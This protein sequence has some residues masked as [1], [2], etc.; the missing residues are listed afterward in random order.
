MNT[1]TWIHKNYDNRSLNNLSKNITEYNT[2]MLLNRGFKVDFSNIIPK[3]GKY[4]V[5]GTLFVDTPLDYYTVEDIGVVNFL[6]DHNVYFKHNTEEIIDV[7]SHKGTYDCLV[8]LAAGTSPIDLAE[9]IGPVNKH[10]IVDISTTA[11]KETNS[12]FNEFF[13]KE[14]TQFTQL[15]F[16]NLDNVEQFLKTVEG[17]KGLIII[18]N[19]FCYAPT[20]LLYDTKLRLEQQNKLMQMLANDKIEWY[21]DILTADGLT[22]RNV[23]AKDLIDQ[24]LDKRLEIIPWI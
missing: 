16:F 13:V 10:Y 21:V 15:D 6:S 23:L 24:Q 5:E 1:F 9:C 19:C 4:A 7:G 17:K 3:I 22:Y 8:S 14:R 11:I 2:T 20:S 18:S 12:Y